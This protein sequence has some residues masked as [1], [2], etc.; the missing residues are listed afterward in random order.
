MQD[1]TIKKFD[2][3]E[4][5]DLYTGNHRIIFEE[6][7]QIMKEDQENIQTKIFKIFLFYH[8]QISVKCYTINV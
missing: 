3:E 7:Y 1:E 8:W 5:K 6:I 4:R 2:Y